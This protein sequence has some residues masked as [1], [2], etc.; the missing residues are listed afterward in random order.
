[1][2]VLSVFG[3]T[4]FRAMRAPFLILAPV[5]VLLGV[6]SAYYQGNTLNYLDIVLV[7]FA[8]L[9]AHIS[10]NTFN[11]YSDFHSGLDAMTQ[12]TPFSGGS[13]ALVEEPEARVQ[14][15][16]AALISLLLCC[17]IGLYFVSKVED[18]VLL[19][20]LGLVGVVVIVSYTDHLN[21]LPWL[22]LISPGLGFGPL[23]V[24]GTHIALS[25]QFS[26]E[27]LLI[28]MLP[29]FLSNNLLLL[30]QFPDRDA[31]QKVGRRHFVIAYGFH[32]SA[33]VYGL[34][35]LGAVFSLLL[36]IF[37]FEWSCW[38]LLCLLPL[39]LGIGIFKTA[40]GFSGDVSGMLSFMGQNVLISLLTPLI[41]ALVLF[42]T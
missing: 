7:M 13:G 30:N 1:M 14:V 4:T 25:G 27:A 40:L 39:L 11:E 31:D 2:P 33:K 9:L 19:L 32:A 18:S 24:L 8:A 6:A 15:W 36:G 42:F 3:S 16:W 37:V 26:L 28:S 38:V 10:V 22:C 5:C 34:M 41:L 17:A 20:S 35:L 23:M 21:R 12:K 29:F